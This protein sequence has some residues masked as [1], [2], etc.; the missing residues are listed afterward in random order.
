[1]GRGM[2]KSVSLRD[3]PD[4]SLRDVLE[5][6]LEHLQLEVVAWEKHDRIQH[7]SVKVKGGKV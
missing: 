4:E 5:A 1:M 2:W 6:I 7:Y 3:V